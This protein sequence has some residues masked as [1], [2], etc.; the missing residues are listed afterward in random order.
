LE[1]EIDTVTEYTLGEDVRLL[2]YRNAIKGMPLVKVKQVKKTPKAKKPSISK[3]QKA[4][5]LAEQLNIPLFS[6]DKTKETAKSLGLNTMRDKLKSMGIEP[7][8]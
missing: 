2:D 4:K 8:A 7:L 5:I 1:S 6:R 3:E